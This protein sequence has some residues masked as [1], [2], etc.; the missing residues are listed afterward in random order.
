MQKKTEKPDS[1]FNSTR[2]KHIQA[3]KKLATKYNR[4]KEQLDGKCMYPHCSCLF[5]VNGPIDPATGKEA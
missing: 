3:T 1:F 5:G 4:C 2:Y